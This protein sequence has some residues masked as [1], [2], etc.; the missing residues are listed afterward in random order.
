MPQPLSI[1]IVETDPAR[2]ALIVASL[3]RA[4]LPL[5]VITVSGCC[6]CAD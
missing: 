6:H 4:P 2:A 5:S 3:S 1:T